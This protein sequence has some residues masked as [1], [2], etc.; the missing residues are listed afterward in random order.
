MGTWKWGV[1]ILGERDRVPSPMAITDTASPS[2]PLAACS[3]LDGCAA[4]A[5]AAG[6]AYAA[7]SEVMRGGTIGK[8]LRHTLDHFEAL[9]AERREGGALDT[10][11]AG[12]AIDY[13]HRSRGGA[14]E[15][16]PGAARARIGSLRARLVGLSEA[17]LAKPV[18]VKVM[19]SGAGE[20]A[21]A[22]S[23]LGRE[24]AF[25][26]HHAIHHQAMMR[27]IAEEQGV[28][29]PSDFGKAPDTIRHERG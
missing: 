20:Q 19:L 5:S 12:G 2:I 15:T 7:E 4:L 16:D 28:A 11:E 26:F 22:S 17:E 9:F 8:H 24:L 1:R 29:V 21:V 18:A 23:T 27:A 25:A 6:V 14:V 13:D 3:V 10:A